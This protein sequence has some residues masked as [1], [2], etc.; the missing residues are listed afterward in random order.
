VFNEHGHANEVKLWVESRLKEE[1]H[2]IRVDALGGKDSVID[3][4]PALSLA[5]MIGLYY[6]AFGA[7]KMLFTDTYV[8]YEFSPVSLKIVKEK[9]LHEEF[10]KALET[11]FAP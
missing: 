9:A 5:P 7:D 1:L 6:A 11:D 3:K 4:L 8:E 10:L 2:R